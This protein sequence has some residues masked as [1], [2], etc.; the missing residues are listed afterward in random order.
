MKRSLAVGIAVF[1][2]SVVGVGHVSAVTIPSGSVVLSGASL[3]KVGPVQCGK[4]KGTW[5]P[6]TLYK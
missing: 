3:K 4:V 6:G 5:I 2:L 1:L